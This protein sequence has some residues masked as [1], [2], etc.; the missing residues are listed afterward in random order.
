VTENA[1]PQLQILISAS[2]GRQ[3]RHQEG[4]VAAV[5]YLSITATISITPSAGREP[6]RY[7]K[8]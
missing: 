1:L 8:G 2:P 6:G 7:G 5:K 4:K 3:G